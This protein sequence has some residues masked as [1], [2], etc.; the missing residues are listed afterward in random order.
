MRLSISLTS[1]PDQDQAQDQLLVP[2]LRSLREAFYVEDS[3]KLAE[4]NEN[5][6]IAPGIVGTRA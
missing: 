5:F 1:W 4:E 3:T 2:V 6:E